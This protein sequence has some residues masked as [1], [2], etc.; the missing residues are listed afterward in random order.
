MNYPFPT[1]ISGNSSATLFQPLHQIVER[2]FAA[3]SSSERIAL[4]LTEVCIVAIPEPQTFIIRPSAEVW[5]RA[6][7]IA[8]EA[9]EMLRAN[10][11][12]E[13]ESLRGLDELL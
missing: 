9:E 3:D 10:R 12:D 11:A 8:Q 6:T 2:Q 7:R 5:Q 4:V 13:A 1:F